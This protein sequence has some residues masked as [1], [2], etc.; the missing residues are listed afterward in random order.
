MKRF[1][2]Y[3]F[4]LFIICGQDDYSGL[5]NHAELYNE[6]SIEKSNS[7]TVRGNTAITDYSGGLTY[8]YPLFSKKI[9]DR[10]N[11]TM[12]L[13]Y[14]NNLST[15]SINK[16]A[17][18]YENNYRI[19]KQPSTFYTD[20]SSSHGQ[21]GSSTISTPGWILNVNGVAVQLLNFN[22]RFITYGQAHSN[23]PDDLYTSG[24]NVQRMFNGWQY[25]LKLEKVTNQSGTNSKNRSKI[26]LMNGDGGTDVFELP[27]DDRDWGG[28][29]PFLEQGREYEL[30]DVNRKGLVAK[31]YYEGN[32]GLKPNGYNYLNSLVV[33]Y[34]NGM[35]VSYKIDFETYLNQ[36]D[37]R[38]TD[39]RTDNSYVHPVIYPEEIITSDNEVIHLIYYQKDAKA[40]RPLLKR[41][42]VGDYYIDLDLPV[43]F[44]SEKIQVTEY[45][46]DKLLKQF[47]IELL[48]PIAEF[49]S[50]D[51]L[52]SRHAL[53]KEIIGPEGSKTK[54]EYEEVSRK[55]NGITYYDNFEYPGFFEDKIQHDIR[56]LTRITEN[57]GRVHEFDYLDV[58]SSFTEMVVGET[59]K[60][61]NAQSN[62]FVSLGRE[63]Y[64]TH[65]IN[66]HRIYDY[67]AGPLKEKI[68][69]EYSSNLSSAYFQNSLGGK[70]LP[71]D[72]TSYTTIKK[73]FNNQNQLYKQIEFEY[74]QY[75]T[76]NYGVTEGLYASLN[77][78]S[79]SAIKLNEKKVYF[80]TLPDNEV[81]ILEL[82]QKENYSYDIGT[83]EGMAWGNSGT[84]KKMSIYNGMFYEKRIDTRTYKNGENIHE[85]VTSDRNYVPIIDTDGNTFTHILLSSS[86]S[87]HLNERSETVYE[88]RYLFDSYEK[89]K[90]ISISD[91]YYHNVVA[92]S[93]TFDPKSNTTKTNITDYVLPMKNN[94]LRFSDYKIFKRDDHSIVSQSSI[95]RVFK[96]VLASWLHYNSFSTLPAKDLYRLLGMNYNDWYAYSSYR[97]YVNGQY[98]IINNRYPD[99]AIPS[100]I[101]TINGVTFP[102]ALILKTGMTIA[103]AVPDINI[104]NTL[105]T[106]PIYSIELYPNFDYVP[107]KMEP[108]FLGNAYFLPAFDMQE[109]SLQG[110]HMLV[111]TDAGYFNASTNQLTFKF[112]KPSETINIYYKILNQD[113]YNQV[114][115]G[116]AER[117]SF[118][119]SPAN[120]SLASVV[121]SSDEATVTMSIPTAS[122]NDARD[123][124]VFI[125]AD[126]SLLSSGSTLYT[127]GYT[128]KHSITNNLAKHLTTVPSTFE[129]SEQ[130][131]KDQFNVVKPVFGKPIRS[132][133][134]NKNETNQLNIVNQ[135]I[136]YGNN[137]L[138]ETSYDSKGNKTS[139][140]PNAA[141]N[142][143]YYENTSKVKTD[144]LEFTGKSFANSHMQKELPTGKII[145]FYVDFDPVSGQAK[146]VINDFNL[147]VK[148][149]YDKLNRIK[150]ITVPK[151]YNNQA[152]DIEMDDYSIPGFNYFEAEVDKETDMGDQVYEVG[153]DYFSQKHEVNIGIYNRNTIIYHKVYD[154][155][156]NPPKLHIV[157]ERKL[158]FYHRQANINLKEIYI[159]DDRFGE[160]TKLEISFDYKRESG[161]L[162]V[163]EL[164]TNT[165]SF[166]YIGTNQFQKVTI[167][168]DFIK[169]PVF[170]NNY[171]PIIDELK[172]R[173]K[174]IDD[175]Y[176]NSQMYIVKNLKVK[177]YGK[178]AEGNDNVATYYLYNDVENKLSY[179][180]TTDQSD[181]LGGYQFL[182]SDYEFDNH[183]RLSKMT[184]YNDLTSSLANSI[185]TQNFYH[186]DDQLNYSLDVDGNKTQL[187][188]NIRREQ[189]ETEFF[190][191][192]STSHGM[193]SSQD[194]SYMNKTTFLAETSYPEPLLQYDRHFTRT[195]SIDEHGIISYEY[196]NN[197]GQKLVTINN[198][199]ASK[200]ADDYVKVMYAYDIYG[201]LIKVIHPNAIDISGNINES[202]CTTYGYDPL[203]Q[204]L[205]WKK[206]PDQE[207]VKYAY[208]QFGRLR[209]SQDGKQRADL[210]FSYFGYDKM[211]RPIYTGIYNG[212]RS[213]IVVFDELYNEASRKEH[214]DM[215]TEFEKVENHLSFIQYDKDPDWQQSIWN[216]FPSTLVKSNTTYMVG[217]STYTASRLKRSDSWNFAWTESDIFGRTVKSSVYKVGYLTEHSYSYDMLDRMTDDIVKTVRVSD[218]YELFTD[219]YHYDYD[220][221]SRLDKV[222]KNGIELSSYTYSK[223]DQVEQLNLANGLQTIDYKYNFR[224]WL[225]QINDPTN[226]NEIFSMKLHYYSNPMGLNIQKNGNIS[227]I[228]SRIKGEELLRI[229]Y[230]YDKVNRLLNSESFGIGTSRNYRFDT[231]YSYDKI[232][233][234][235]SLSRKGLK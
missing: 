65:I 70:Y 32:Y 226:V 127:G 210:V 80:N 138:A 125:V 39:E 51:N 25:Q 145:N 108:K 169:H 9:S 195:K 35:K 213:G 198:A 62:T 161:S 57:S 33:L 1:I 188:Y 214:F 149:S 167:S 157:E 64:N 153:Y 217:K 19:F 7:F 59:A 197:K 122:I 154:Y 4:L 94:T 185:S 105:V 126:P 136:D 91:N 204:T 52:H 116:S 113:E 130:L 160:F 170:Q 177:I 225:E 156:V 221:L 78:P 150:D 40:I 22:N 15:V 55:H 86:S 181:N 53:I 100:T 16:F 162:K 203:Y 200:S 28:E 208:D 60:K 176:P 5:F 173:L 166:N 27:I 61:N 175:L 89:I 21:N 71:T 218:N 222:T 97:L 128:L 79:T 229:G 230:E 141:V 190:E 183:Y 216:Q 147:G 107:P 99:H 191:G 46:K 37:I 163:L 102:S 13:V 106:Q 41:I 232:G 74:R 211:D 148:Y 132:F 151:L 194:Y 75:H 140:F 43:F 118:I 110:M 235:K 109:N 168:R 155:E 233:N 98:Y 103:A 133:T 83:V 146:H 23:A 111:E 31:L 73:H 164:V 227:G 93:E 228:E 81:P 134:I 76:I 72:E 189:V 10:S 58:E 123:Y 48:E 129:N 117:N 8:N 187:K 85:W 47:N 104:R 3:I 30:I 2:F 172:F 186:F 234:I 135:V 50:T 96:D 202:L 121:N 192:S 193:K 119:N 112:D 45:Y 69:Y 215:N 90:N 26:E 201:N 142:N 137:R 88:D 14:N 224:G 68:S 34:P 152:T 24:N 139:F 101:S 44:P 87:N 231:S 29:W 54:F 84:T 120:L 171:L 20:L 131:N 184:R 212:T 209:F 115:A 12:S 11:L 56:R 206:L 63:A 36:E 95:D 165:E 143:D 220:I 219:N 18:N 38:S 114:K 182:K 180:K 205:S 82:V 6:K 178:T 144:E 66:E 67:V 179:Y 174:D 223:K 207:I 92:K 159:N 42:Q 199:L 124:G 49:N 196:A 77:D 17:F 158:R